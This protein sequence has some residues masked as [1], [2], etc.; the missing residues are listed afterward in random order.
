MKKNI[1]LLFGGRS[2]EHEVSLGSA[3]FI[4][5]NLDLKKYQ[6]FFVGI[7]KKGVWFLTDK[8]ALSKKEF[9]SGL[10]DKKI[11]L[12][13]G[14]KG[15]TFLSGGKRGPKI[16]LVFPI[17]HGPLGE[18]GTIQG[19]LKLVRVPF[20]GANVLGSAVGM[21][22]DIMKRL[23][24][25]AGLPIGKFLVINNQKKVLLFKDIVK[26]IGC[27]FF[28]KPANT[29]SSVGVHKVSNLKDYKRFLIDALKFDT[30]VILEELIKG[31]EIEC[32]ILG[33]EK[34]QASLPG[35]IIVHHDFYSYEAKYLDE[36]GAHFVIPA[37]ISPA[38]IKEIKDLAI[39]VF[40]V[41]NCSGLGRVDFFLQNNGKIIINEINTLP[42]FTSISMYP[43]M[44]EVSGIE[45]KDLL[46]SLVDLALEKFKEEEKILTSI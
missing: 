9:K 38:K 8:K 22:K 14:L 31:R 40:Q 25:E 13:P 33:N 41:L 6:L 20:V 44:W 39:K 28:I 17:L 42:G 15:E 24:K 46:N 34:P 27:P 1:L 5:N 16:D 7:D 36:N 10:N 43:K 26:K 21:D 12:I 35:E 2:T 30:K 3:N 32:S 18:D 37:K 19:L 4:A 23:L 11:F 29:G 45:A